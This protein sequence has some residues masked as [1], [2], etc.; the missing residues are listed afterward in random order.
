MPVPHYPEATAFAMEFPGAYSHGTLEGSIGHNP[1]QQAPDT[2][3][4]AEV[5][6]HGT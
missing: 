3:A 5:G 6:G 4:D 2:Y 1:P